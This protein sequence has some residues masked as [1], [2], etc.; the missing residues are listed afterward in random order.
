M[1]EGVGTEIVEACLTLQRWTTDVLSAHMRMVAENK[2]L[3]K[4][5]REQRSV[6]LRDMSSA[7]LIGA[8][9]SAA[10]GTVRLYKRRAAAAFNA[11]WSKRVSVWEL[12]E[13]RSGNVDSWYTFKAG[14]QRYLEDQTRTAKSSLLISKMVQPHERCEAGKAEPERP[15][16]PSVPEPRADRT[17]G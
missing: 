3:P 7:S 15:P 1:Q 4:A 5:T 2:L 6:A 17:G 14:V 9:K 16:E 12:V 8:T 10:D 13:Q 11:A